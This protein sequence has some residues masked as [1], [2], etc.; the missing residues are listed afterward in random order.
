MTEPNDPAFSASEHDIAS[1]MGGTI[2]KTDKEWTA[3][4]AL[5]HA[6]AL[7]ARLNK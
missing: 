6:D 5:A 7:I 1:G 4:E 3:N 2:F